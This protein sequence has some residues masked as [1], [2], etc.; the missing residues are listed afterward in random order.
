VCGGGEKGAEVPRTR[1][2][3]GRG[4]AGFPGTWA[5]AELREMAGRVEGEMTSRSHSA[6]RARG[7]GERRARSQARWAETP[8]ERGQ[9]GCFSFL[10]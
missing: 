3:G 7:K 8:G 6:A 10:Y 9:L 4:E 5:S 2:V 1:D